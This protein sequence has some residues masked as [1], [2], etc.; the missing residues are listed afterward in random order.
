MSPAGLGDAANPGK[1]RVMGAE[2]PGWFEMWCG[3]IPGRSL[4]V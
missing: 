4:S 2:I 3:P 1:G